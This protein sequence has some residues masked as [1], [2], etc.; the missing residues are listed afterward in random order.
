MKKILLVLC[1][2]A[3]SLSGAFGQKRT[4]TF[5]A[6]DPNIRYV[7]RVIKLNS[8]SVSF[9]WSGTYLMTRFEGDYCAMIVSDTKKNYYNVFI[10][11]QLKG[12]VTTS[13]K[14]SLVVLADGLKKGL[15]SLMLQKRSEGE[16]GKTTIH[17]FR[18]SAKGRFLQSDVKRERHIEFI[19]NS[20]TCGYG[21]EGLSKR[22]PFKVETENCNL[23][24]GCIISRYFNADYT[25]IS[26]SGR[27]AARNYGDTAR[28]SKRTM[29]DLMLNT[30][31]WDKDISVWN[32]KDYYPDLVV[33]N[34]GSNDFST[35]PHPLKEEFLKA[36]GQIINQIRDKYGDIP[37][38][39]VAP[40]KGPAFAY[41]QE[42][43]SNSNDKNLHFTA[44]LNGVYNGDSDQ[45]S[46]GHP[47]YEGQKKIA[48]SLIPYI[49]TIT[50]W[51]LTGEAVK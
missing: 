28:V 1:L 39:C 49:S 25:L 16:Q 43:C 36:Y 23:A 46:S 35:K 42:Y 27:G 33:I 24:Y 14:D 38:L 4:E 31:D 5:R 30:F 18:L 48:M 21:T 17:S 8:G 32:F 44:Y 29:K 37:V 15:H 45:G 20:I 51:S 10:D 7:G 9:D 2:V 41:I 50:G 22:E 47:N 26:H 13:G 19:G 12:V 6:D 11:N 40:P 3:M 34:L